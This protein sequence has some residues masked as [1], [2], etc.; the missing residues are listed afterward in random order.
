M[1]KVI[2]ASN[3]VFSI[4][5]ISTNRLQQNPSSLSEM[6]IMLD[7]ICIII[8]RSL[9]IV[10]HITAGG[11]NLSEAV[12]QRGWAPLVTHSQGRSFMNTQTLAR[13][14]CLKRPIITS[15]PRLVSRQTTEL[16]GYERWKQSSDHQVIKASLTGS[17]EGEEV[18]K[19]EII[20]HFG[21]GSPLSELKLFLHAAWIPSGL[22][23][24][25]TETKCSLLWPAVSIK[26]G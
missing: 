23:T 19:E 8:S 3:Q 1:F 16:S 13:S 21:S 26:P 25:L 4:S 2:A 11:G 10:T 7:S 24:M 15:C 22:L 6:G 20:R 17:Y 5:K 12:H 9:M 14:P 18:Q